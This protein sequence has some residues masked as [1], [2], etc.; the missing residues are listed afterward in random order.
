MI[1]FTQTCADVCIDTQSACATYHS[2]TLGRG[3]HFEH[4]HV[5]T[6]E[7]EM[8][9]AMLIWGRYLEV[10]LCAGAVRK[11]E[12]FHD[13]QSLQLGLDA[14]VAS[15]LDSQVVPQRLR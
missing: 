3:G 15:V 14:C 6:R 13:E 8:Q 1:V 11:G 9:P 10:R 2:K 7:R 12:P 4:G 5:Y